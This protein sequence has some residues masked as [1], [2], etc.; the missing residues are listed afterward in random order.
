MINSNNKNNKNNKNSKGCLNIKNNKDKFI[1]NIHT[2]AIKNCF[3]K[4]KI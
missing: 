1:S 4:I 3:P 2:K